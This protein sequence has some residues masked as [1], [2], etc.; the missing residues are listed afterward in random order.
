MRTFVRLAVAACVLHVVVGVGRSV[1]AGF[2]VETSAKPGWCDSVPNVGALSGFGVGLL[3]AVSGEGRENALVSPLGIGAVLA[4]LTPGAKDPVRRSIWEMLGVGSNHTESTG[5]DAAETTPAAGEPA[6]GATSA[7]DT[8]A[9]DDDRM[10]ILVYGEDDSRM[11][12][13]VC[14]LERVKTDHPK[15]K[16]GE[17]VIE[18]DG[19]AEVEMA[20][21]AFADRRLDLFPAFAAVLRDRFSVRVER[22]DFSDEGSVGRINSWVDSATS[23]AIP[24]LV[25]SLEPD[26]V[27][28]LVNALRFRGEWTHRFDPE[29]TAPAPFHLRSGASV[30][31]PAMQADDLPARYREDDGFQAVALPYGDGDFRFVVV[32]PR[33]GT[34]APDALRRLAA[35]PSWLEVRGF[36]RSRGS[37]TLPRMT[38]DEDVSLLPVLRQL[39]LES[40]LEDTQ[41][42]AGIAAPAPTLSRVLHRTMLVLDEKG[43]EAAAA[44]AAVMTTRSAPVEDRFEVKV[45]RPFAF[46]VVHR[47]TGASLFVGWVANP[48]GG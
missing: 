13:L 6:A 19:G 16:D 46:A 43:T 42:F 4:M 5:T 12:M 27:L 14:Q 28:V 37:L 10:R 45:D 33:A 15:V 1:S 35:D 29:R 3:G 36:R 41:A 47:D 30:E 20:N 22:L 24:R 7:G 8:Y 9:G 26:D 18:H 31:V 34:A 39:G 32:L 40:A 23:G 38:L 25:S 44:T 11:R 2:P 21:G 48:L 17:L